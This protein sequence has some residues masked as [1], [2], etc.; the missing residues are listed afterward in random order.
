MLKLRRSLLPE[1]RFWP[2]VPLAGL[3]ILAIVGFLTST[4]SPS[5]PTHAKEQGNNTRNTINEDSSVYF[6]AGS[7]VETHNAAIVAISTVLLALV[8]GGLV[9]VAYVQLR[10][11]RRQ[12]RAYV[13]LT[14]K[15]ILNFL[16]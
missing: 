4:H 2:A 12:L 11:T 6:A 13:A 9:W 14:P 3:L 10:T 1:W 5:Q 15:T 8:T 16:T 7:F